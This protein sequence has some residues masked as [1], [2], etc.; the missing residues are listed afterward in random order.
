MGARAGAPRV[1]LVISGH[2]HYYE[3]FRSANGVTYVVTGGGGY[4]LYH[5]AHVLH[6]GGVPPRHGDTPPLARDRGPAARASPSRSG[7]AHR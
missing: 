7:R 6:G 5:A 1:A 3:R 2:D 4:D